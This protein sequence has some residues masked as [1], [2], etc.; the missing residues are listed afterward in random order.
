MLLLASNMRHVVYN[1]TVGSLFQ[2]NYM[3]LLGF[4][5]GNVFSSLEG[6]EFIWEL[7]TVEGIGPVN[8]QSV[9]R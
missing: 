4:V 2:N 5:T 6:I 9:L 7:K 1:Y 3:L 8:A